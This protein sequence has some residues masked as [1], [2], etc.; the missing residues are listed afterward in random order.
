MVVQAKNNSSWIVKNIW[1]Q[2]KNI[3]NLQ[4]VWDHMRSSEKFHMKKVYEELITDKP[5]V[6]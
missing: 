4:A 6:L 3:S 5:K 2:R 1:Q